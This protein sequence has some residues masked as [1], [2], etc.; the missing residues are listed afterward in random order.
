MISG[1]LARFGIGRAPCGALSVAT[2]ATFPWLS[3]DGDR[4]RLRR[5]G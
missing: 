2:L 5:L 3:E 1:F 4:L